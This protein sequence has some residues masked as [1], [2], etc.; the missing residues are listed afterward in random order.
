M[1]IKI[2][3][4]RHLKKN[5]YKKAVITMSILGLIFV[6]TPLI[7]T[8]ASGRNNFLPS[9][10]DKVLTMKEWVLLE[11]YKAG[12]GMQDFECLVRNESGWREMAYYVNNDKSVDRGLM[13]WNSK[14]NSHI[15][16]EC[17]FSYRCAVT[18]AI[19]K[20]KKDGGYGAW[21]AYKAH[22]K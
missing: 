1:K 5:I 22:C 6:L 3:T 8:K 13:M 14:W 21:Y 19:K 9:N 7:T 16:N 11:A 10:D 12:L 20:I 2:Q 15:S 4:K 18:E 17:A